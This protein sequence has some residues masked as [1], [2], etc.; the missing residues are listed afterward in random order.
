M[1]LADKINELIKELIELDLDG[2]KDLVHIIFL[3]DTPGPYGY[4]WQKGYFVINIFE[5]IYKSLGEEIPEAQENLQKA[6]AHNLTHFHKEHDLEGDLERVE[7]LIVVSGVLKIQ[8]AYEPLVEM[9]LSKR[10]VDAIRGRFHLN[11]MRII[12]LFKKYDDRIEQ[13]CLENIENVRHLGLF[14]TYYRILGMYD[15]KH[16]ERYFDEYIHRNIAGRVLLPNLDFIYELNTI[17]VDRLM[18]GFLSKE[19]NTQIR[20]EV[21]QIYNQIRL[22]NIKNR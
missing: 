3:N 2:I 9:A 5:E 1:V 22:R 8:Q 21:Q 12:E 10:Y 20:D 13:F 18:Q 4:L 6:I 19:N 14:N 17:I 16:L 7:E 15:E 11:L